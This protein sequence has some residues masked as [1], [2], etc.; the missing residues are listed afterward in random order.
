VTTA[1]AF[2][3]VFGLLTVFHELGHF[4]MAKRVGILVEEF[5]VGFGPLVVSRVIGETRYSL[6][7]FPLGGYVRMLGEEEETED[8]ER[9]FRH[10]PVPSRLLVLGAGPLMN[11]L[12]AVFL[13]AVIFFWLGVPASG[14]EIA[15]VI[16]GGPAAEAGLQGGDRIVRIEGKEVRTWDQV[17]KVVSARAGEQTSITVERAGRSLTV[18]LVPRPAEDDGRGTIGILRVMDRHNLLSSFYWGTRQTVGTTLFILIRLGQ[19]LTQQAPADVAGPVGIVQVV[20]EVA[21]TGFLNLLSLA[22]LL[23]INLGLFNLFPIPLLDGGQLVVVGW[24][25]L[26]GKPLTPEREGLIKLVGVILLLAILALATYHDFMRLG[27]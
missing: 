3:F 14:S 8:N 23:S 11:F 24:E 15:D 17:V 18:N 21:Q 2:I 5:A 7:L 25:G 19:M 4:L 6:R 22:A 12:L 10:R 9:S 13:F 26:T 20:G 1:L 16:P 27:V